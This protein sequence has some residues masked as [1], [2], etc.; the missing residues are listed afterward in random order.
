MKLML[1]MHVNAVF[2]IGLKPN[3]ITLLQINYRVMR[4]NTWMAQ[5]SAISRVLYQQKSTAAQFD[6]VE[7]SKQR[8]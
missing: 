3:K 6:N 5:V 8:F 1:F 7:L 4:N 2:S